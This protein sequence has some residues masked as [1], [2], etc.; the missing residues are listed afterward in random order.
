MYSVIKLKRSNMKKPS[1]WKILLF[2]F[3]SL[4]VIFGISCASAGI[5]MLLWNWIMPLFGVVTLTFWQTWGIQLLFGII[6]SCL[7]PSNLGAFEKEIDKLRK[8]AD[9]EKNKNDISIVIEDTES[10]PA[11]TSSTSDTNE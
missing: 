10:E 8:C 6:T 7:R 3:L 9:K 5:L 4:V 11:D 2:F 1:I